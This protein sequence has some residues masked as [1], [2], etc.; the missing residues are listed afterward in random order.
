MTSNVGGVDRASR[1]VVGLAILS[2]TLFLEGEVRWF[3]LLGLIP[4]ATGILATCPAYSLLGISTCASGSPAS[5]R[6]GRA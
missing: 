5:G 1:I 3:G 4:L 6:G 2:L